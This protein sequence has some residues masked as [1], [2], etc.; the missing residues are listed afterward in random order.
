MPLGKF[1]SDVLRV[2]SQNRSPES[3]VAG[4]TVLNRDENTPRISNDID[5]FNDTEDVLLS[6]YQSD[7]IS[8]NAAGYQ[9][10]LQKDFS[11]FKRVLVSKKDSR[12]K[13]EWA[14]DSAF[15]FFPAE[16]DP[17]LGYCL[18]RW[19]AATNKALA[20]AGRTAIR[21]YVDLLHLHSNALSLGA[22]IW[23]ASAKDGGLSPGFILE[24]MQR[25]QRYPAE[26]YQKL[27]MVKPCDPVQLKHL[28]LEAIQDAKELFDLLIDL[29]APYGC[30]FLNKDGEPETPNADTLSS[31]Q[32]HYG[33]LRGCWPRSVEED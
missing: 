31:L 18:N 26:E 28:W 9:T 15:R 2:I 1:E 13:I 16:P 17:Q 33:S 11:T 3:H 20:A 7:M 22:I 6:A 4:A 8:L 12:T 10:E 23:A 29:D 25:I 19:D 27:E 24:E 21:D 32:P 30:F 5:L 14:R